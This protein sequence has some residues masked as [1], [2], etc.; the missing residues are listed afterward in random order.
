MS[1]ALETSVLPIVFGAM[2][3]PL[4]KQLAGYDIEAKRIAK[5]QREADAITMLAV[6]GLLRD[7]EKTRA[8]ERLMRTILKAVN[9][10]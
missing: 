9:D 2:A 4:K 10:K 8:R 7:P 1:A 3:D 5:W 6:S